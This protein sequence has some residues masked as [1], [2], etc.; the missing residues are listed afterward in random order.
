MIT[1]AYPSTRL[2][3]LRRTSFLRDLVQ[4]TRL[5]AQDLIAPFFIQEGRGLCTPI[6]SMPGIYRYTV[7]TL[8]PVVR[9][10]HQ[11]GLRMIALFPAIVS[12]KKSEK[13]EE[14]YHPDGLIPRAI[15][16]LKQALPELGVMGD[17]AL[18][19]YTVH[20]QDGVVDAQGRVLNDETNEALVRQALVLAESGV[21]VIAPSDMMDGRIG[22]IRQ[23]LDARG[24]IETSIL[25]YS[26]KYAS[27]FYGPFRTAVGSGQAL[28]QADKKSYQLDPANSAE[29]LREV[30]L[31]IQEGADWIMV[32]PGM[33]YLDIL[34]R[35]KTEFQMPTVAYQVSGEYAMVRAA[36]QQGWLSEAAIWESLLCFKR[37]GADA[38]MTYFAP[39]I[40][41][42]GLLSC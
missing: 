22:V 16:I 39:W 36:I 13:G 34:Y 9:R 35:V 11:Q 38:I 25:A 17:V 7:D 28:G 33:S 30:A 24:Y 15:R 1:G 29:A 23:A 12:D 19:P 40:L 8:L 21:D 14:A 20:G 3:R 10:C 26:A 31:D 4:E 32:K 18:D 6:D 2:R 42:R 37:A 27:A 5:S 41:E